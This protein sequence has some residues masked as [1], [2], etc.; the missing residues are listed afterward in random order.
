MLTKMQK[1]NNN[2]K[3]LER[4]VTKVES[5]IDL[6]KKEQNDAAISSAKIE[7]KL[8][9]IIEKVDSQEAKFDKVICNF[10]NKKDGEKWRKVS[11]I[12]LSIIIGSILTLFLTT[13]LDNS[14]DNTTTNT[15]VVK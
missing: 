11:W 6:I 3:D 7:M 8:D 12:I 10:E 5:D 14:R 2:M 1:E 4:R 9:S 15:T 13:I